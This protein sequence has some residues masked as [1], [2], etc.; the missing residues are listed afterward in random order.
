MNPGII[1]AIVI[2]VLIVIA[3]V[4]FSTMRKRRTED[5]R[6]QFGSEY[7]R[8]VQETGDQRAAESELV[9]RRQRVE[10]LDTRP[11]T[12]E[13]SEQYTTAWRDVQARFVDDPN[14]AIGDADNLIADV[15]RTRGYPASVFEQRADIM[16]VEYGD[17]VSDYRS[18][19]DLAARSE[20]GEA[21]T[22]DL[23]NAMLQYRSLFERLVA[24]PQEATTS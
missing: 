5:L 15:M 24:T 22:E 4:A 13:E 12:P 18:A 7:D 23:R 19:H 8:T 20:N 17:V 10:K 14:G 1:A 9:E 6:G 2:V 21:T 16:S 11:L 3:L